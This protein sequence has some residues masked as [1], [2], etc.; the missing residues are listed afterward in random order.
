MADADDINR[1][2]AEKAKAEAKAAAK[3]RVIEESADSKGKIDRLQSFIN[4][5]SFYEVSDDHKGLLTGQLS[6]MQSYYHTLQLRLK[7]CD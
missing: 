3:Q 1:Q 4:G 6:H 5:L 2:N 7:A